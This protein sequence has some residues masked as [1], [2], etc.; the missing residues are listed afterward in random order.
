MRK[1]I[2]LVSIF[3][4][5]LFL[6][7]KGLPKTRKIWNAEVPSAAIDIE[8]DG[9]VSINN[10]LGVDGNATIS[11]SITMSGSAT[12][13]GLSLSTA[14]LNGQIPLIFSVVV[15]TTSVSPTAAGQIILG[16][17]YNL[18]VSSASGGS[19]YKIGGK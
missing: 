14:T 3:L 10:N 6:F 12:A 4:F 13:D 7:S 1:L 19:W 2:V 15:D 11:G 8:S 18:Y 17:D 5:G 9:D 16:N